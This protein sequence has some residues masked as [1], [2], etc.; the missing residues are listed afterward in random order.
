MISLYNLYKQRYV[1]GQELGTR[2]INSNDL[3][4]E[5]LEA[6]RRAAEPEGFVEGLAVTELEEPPEPEISLEEIRAEAEQIL[7]E[8]RIRSEDLVSKANEQVDQIKESARNEGWRQG[9]ED[10]RQKANE[11]LAAEQEKIEQQRTALSEHYQQKLSEM[12]G[13]VLTAVCDVMEQVFHIQFDEFGDILLHLVGQ[14]VRQIESCKEFT[15]R[16]HPEQYEYLNSHPQELAAQLGPSVQ[17]LL[18]ADASMDK[19]GCVI[20]TDSGFF[21]CSLDVQFAN[22]IKAIRMLSV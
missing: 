18:E 15:V 1:V 20:E 22:L 8:A 11:E 14:A 4:A 7:E 2:I 5:K 10:G 9:Y 19:S 3:V 17:I 21:D 13:Q 6:Q 16:V 12:E